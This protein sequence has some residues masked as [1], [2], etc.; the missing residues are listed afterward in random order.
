MNK[1]LNKFFITAARLSAML[2]G[3]VASAVAL[4]ACAQSTGQWTVKVGENLIMPKVDSSDLSGPGPAGAKVDVQ[5]AYAPVISAAYM[6]T[7]NISTELVIG[8]P[9]RHDII[10]K[11]SIDGVGKIGDLQQLP[12][13]LFAQ[14]R[15]MEPTQKFRPY[16]GLGLTYAYFRDTHASPTLVALLGPTTIKVDSKFAVTPQV[17]ASYAINQRWFLDTSLTKTFLKTTAIL[18][19]ADTR[20]TIDTKL[21]PVAFSVSVG[22]KF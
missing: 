20:R 3:I 5:N 8:F 18:T 22:Y 2:T 15:F 1:S 4:P 21:D 19:S 16:L 11:G 13:T 14:Y 12:P 6:I 10:G 17:G 7:D 9:Y